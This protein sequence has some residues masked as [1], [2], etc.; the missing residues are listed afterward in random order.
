MYGLNKY[1]NRYYVIMIPVFLWLLLTLLI[2]SNYYSSSISGF[3]VFDL[4]VTIPFLYFL[5][6]RKK[7]VSKITVLSIF[8]M[9]TVIGSYVLPK[10]DQFFLEV[11]K[12]F[13]V[14]VIEICVISFVV[15]KARL[16]YKSIH[17]NEGKGDFFDA[18]TVACHEVLPKSLA[19]FLATEISVFYYTFFSWKNTQLKADEYSYHKEGTYK[20]IFLGFTLILIIETFVLHAFLM[21][22][23]VVLAWITNLLS[24]YTLL[25]I[26]A[27]YKTISKRPIYIDEKNKKL[28]LQFGIVGKATIA[29]ENI[30][31]IKVSTADLKNPNIQYFSFIGSLSGHNIVLSFKEPVDYESLYGKQ[32]KAKALAFIIDDK[33]AFQKRIEELI[34]EA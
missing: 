29:L 20:G 7:E 26:I 14:P 15:Y 4:L 22:S 23:N 10:K 6:I 16:L 3:I 33:I 9:G 17:K 5:S 25:Q 13:I 28:I 32:K 27:I 1:M 34:G 30:K 12:S 19:T 21:K 2:Q 24:I 18:I 11:I 8:V 31:L